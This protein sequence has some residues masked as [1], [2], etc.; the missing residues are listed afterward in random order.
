MA[1]DDAWRPTFG[2]RER[3]HARAGH[4]ADTRAAGERTGVP[5]HGVV[6]QQHDRCVHGP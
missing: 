5:G 4:D 6:G 3:G 1:A 2:E